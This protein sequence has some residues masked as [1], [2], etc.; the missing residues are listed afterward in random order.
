MSYK[1]VVM[2]CDKNYDLWQPFYW[3]MEKYWKDHPEIIYSTETLTNPFYKTVA[4]NYPIEKWTKRVYETI[5]DLECDNVLLMVDDLF[6]RKRVDNNLV[7]V[8]ES[9]VGGI[10]GALNFE[11]SFDS[12][13]TPL[14]YLIALRNPKGKWKTSV[15][16]QM[17]NKKA[18]LDILRVEK[19]KEPWVFERDNVGLNYLFLI[20]NYG[21]II[22]WGYGNRKWFGIRKGKWCKEIVEFFN[23]EGIHIDYSIR[24]FYE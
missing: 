16:C 2:S 24:G 7:N 3:C 11:K 5:K 23:N 9:C 22:D 21:N 4:L 10:I 8:A 14:D 6:I 1:I 19:D 17:W 20:T 13:D 12:L 18:L 15:M